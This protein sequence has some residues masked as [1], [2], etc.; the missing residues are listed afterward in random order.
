MLSIQKLRNKAGLLIIIVIG[1]ALVAFILGDIMSPKKSS[2]F[3]KD[4]IIL[5]VDGQKIPATTYFE[6]Q[7][8]FEDNYQANGSSLDDNARN[9]IAMQAWEQLL[10]Q[11]ILQEQY[12]KLGLGIMMPEHGV[13]G[14]SHEELKDMIVGNNI[15]PQIQQIFR[16]PQ[17]GMYDKNFALNFLQNMDSDPAKKQIWL[18]IEKQLVENRMVAKYSALLT[19]GVY[20]TTAE[21]KILAKERNHKVDISYISVPFY[22]MPDSLFKPTTEEM[23]A[24]LSKHKEDYKQLEEGRDI[25]YI[26]FPIQPSNEDIVATRKFV[27]DLAPDFKTTD[28][29]EVFVNTNSTVPFDSKFVK[30]GTLPAQIDSFAFSGLKGSLIGPYFDGEYIKLSKISKIA[31]MPDSVK[32]RHILVTKGDARKTIDSLKKE[33]EKGAN[34]ALLAFKYSEDP[35]SKN[36][37][38]DLGWFPEGK[39][40]GPFNDS[41]FLG[42]VGKLY[43]VETRYGVHLV[44][45][46]EKGKETKKVQIATIAAKIEPSTATKNRI[47]SEANKFA[48]MN[49]TEALFAK[50]VEANGGKDKKVASDLKS[51]DR[52]IAGVESARQVIRW[53]YEAKQGD[54][55]AVFDCNKQYIIAC[56]KN[57]KEKGYAELASVKP[58]IEAEVAK[59]KKSTKILNDIKNAGNVGSL[60]ELASKLKNTM[61]R[62]AI[63]VS[64][65]NTSIPGVGMEPKI[66]GVASV[67]ETGKISKPIVGNNGVYV[68]AV[69]KTDDAPVTNDK[70]EQAQ[71]ANMLKSRFG[72]FSYNVLKEKAEITDNRLQFE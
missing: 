62:D 52:M 8:Q 6:L 18:T 26:A 40:V 71:N 14:I 53:A 50:A 46:Q 29:D 20:T 4:S 28:N 47:Y 44:E 65:G 10:R 39:M 56:L 43:V 25:D 48:G 57:V 33:I 55:S 5:K 7:K 72:Y 13:I 69:I 3:Q 59:E 45:L 38:G 19:Q 30:K 34:F 41:C 17:T 11:S 22:T 21:A 32:A 60:N 63:G 37:G 64:F 12:E 61:V 24:Y 16:N 49:N 2:I 31:M 36:K 42:K 58:Q 70:A 23:E 1:L 15:D 68:I 67:L 27:A 51:G 54:V 9:M 35:G 66:A